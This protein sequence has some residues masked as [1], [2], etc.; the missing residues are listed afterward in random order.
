MKRTLVLTILALFGLTAAHAQKQVAM[1]THGETT[2]VYYGGNALVDAVAAAD[3]GDVINLSSGSFAAPSSIENKPMLTIRGAGR[4]ADTALGTQPTVINGEMYIYPGNLVFEGL[5]ITNTIQSTST[6]SNT[7]F[8]DCYFDSIVKGGEFFAMNDCEFIQ[9]NVKMKN[10]PVSN[11]TFTNCVVIGEF[12]TNCVCNNCVMSNW[13][14]DVVANNSIITCAYYDSWTQTPIDNSNLTNCVGLAFNSWTGPIHNGFNASV[15]S[16]GN[17][18]ADLNVFEDYSWVNGNG[19]NYV[20]GETYRLTDSAA[21]TYLG[22]DG[23]QVGVYGG[24]APWGHSRGNKVTVPNQSR[25]DG[26]LEVTIQS[27][28]Q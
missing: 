28:N 6:C 1:L 20:Y 3:S 18:N 4:Y 10:Q 24:M 12:G 27:V 22:S 25:T 21:A 5:H 15:I 17:Y 2:T 13:N 16:A 19:W 14:N 26:K 9:C 23:T 8:I 7:R 11:S